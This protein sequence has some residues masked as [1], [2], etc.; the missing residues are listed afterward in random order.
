MNPELVKQLRDPMKFIKW[1]WPSYTLYDAQR[2]T[3]Y[4][5]KNNRETYVVAANRTGKDF[6]AGLIA[7]GGILAPATFLWRD[8]VA[9]PQPVT[10]LEGKKLYNTRIVT[11]SVKDDHLDILWG[12]I[13]RFIRTAKIPL[14]SEQGGP[15]VYLSKGRDIRKLVNGKEERDTYLKAQVASKPEG[16]AGHHGVYTLMLMDEASGIDNQAYEAGQGW[17]KRLLAQGNPNAGCRNFFYKNIKA[18]DLRET[19]T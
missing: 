18:G 11:T 16:L 15:L 3:I 4:S 10:T 17:M 7:L 12:E 9:A 19:V 6:T 5:V 8:D 1:L 14:L 2:E 13:D